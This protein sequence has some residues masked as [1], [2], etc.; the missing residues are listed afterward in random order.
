[1]KKLQA[2]KEV[3]ER[4]LSD[5]KRKIKNVLA[6]KIIVALGLQSVIRYI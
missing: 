1:M 2:G 5:A 6:F 3:F 4:L